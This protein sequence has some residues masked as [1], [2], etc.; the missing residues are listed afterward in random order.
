MNPMKRIILLSIAIFGLTLCSMAA[1]VDQSTAKSVASKFMG[2]DKVQLATTYRTESNAA[3][4][5]VFNTADGFVIVAADDCETPI[6]GYSHEGRF[7]PNNIPVQMEEYLQDFVARIQYGI[8]KQIVADETTAR[9]WKLVKATGKLGDDKSAKAVAPLLTE[10][11]HQGCLY[12]SLCPAMEHTPC[13]H[14]EAGCVAVAMGQIMHYWKYPTT[15]WGSHSYANAGVTLSADFGSTTYDWEHMPDS[16]TES[17][18]E[19]EVNTV[20]TL[21]YHCGVAVNMRYTPTSSG[22]NAND[23]PNALIRY[24]NYS[25]RLHIEKR[26]DY[27]TEE[28]LLMLKNCLDL[29][30][31]V[32]YAGHGDQ[33]GHAFVCDGYDNN[34]LL[35]FNWG[36]G[37][38][39]G[40]FSLGNLNPLVYTFNKSQSAIFDIYPHYDPC[41][42]FATANPPTAGTIEGAGEYHI[43]ELCTLTV[44]TVTDIDFYC[45]KRNDQIIS[46]TPSYTFGVEADTIC[47]EANFCHYPVGE[48][49]VNYSPEANNPNCTSVSLS[50]S[51]ADTEWIL[52]KQFDINEELGGMATDDEFIY[53]TYAEWNSPPFTFGKYTMD[54]DLVEQFNIENFTGVTCLAYDGTSFYCNNAPGSYKIMYRVDLDNKMILD[55]TTMSNWFGTLTYDPEYDGFWL[56]HNY[57][58]FLFDRQGHRIKSSPSTFFD[59]INGTG[60]FIAE[61][62]NPHL[63][64]S[65]ELGVYDY[66]INNNYIFDQPLLTFGG[67]ANESLGTCTGKYDGKDALFV[68]VGNTVYIYDVRSNLAQIVGYR[69]YRADSEGHTVVLADE[70]TSTSYIDPTWSSAIAGMYRFG[71]SS[72]FANGNES[73]IVW[74]DFIEKTDYG[75]SENIGNPTDSSVRKVF[76]NGQII[77]IKDG[78]RYNVSG[79]QLN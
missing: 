58:T 59:Y 10:E 48:I 78:K 29:Q 21:L 60:Y 75:T 52:L 9:Q 30:Q 67:E 5:Y 32:F 55:S 49:T 17:S 40:Y 34:D 27:S 3:A 33:G 76:E 28:W 44:T 71:I 73:E 31:P 46:S 47:I 54:G 8:E 66:D 43:G 45:W 23:V 72:I 50:W 79:Q 65:R 14:A 25:K 53:V 4:L 37:V 77:I 11:W 35:H 6:I 12:N 39:N 1:P 63:L 51:R 41:L 16:L 68:V 19:T 24:F 74:S 7:D 38:A 22:A 15:G 64:M 2:A 36:W 18:S 57:Q 62:G 20:A 69:L 61:D 56:G 13:G 70:V 42:V 26:N